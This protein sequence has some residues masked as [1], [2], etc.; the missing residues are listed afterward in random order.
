[1]KFSL[2]VFVV[3]ILGTSSVAE[4]VNMSSYRKDP[5]AFEPYIYSSSGSCGSA[6]LMSFYF[7]IHV[8]R[9][10][11]TVKE[12]RI[13]L[14]S[15][16]GSTPSSTPAIK[17]AIVRAVPEN[18]KP[19]KDSQAIFNPQEPY[20]PIFVSEP[21]SPKTFTLNKEVEVIFDFTQTNEDTPFVFDHHTF[22]YVVMEQCGMTIQITKTEKEFLLINADDSFNTT[23]ALYGAGLNGYFDVSYTLLDF[24]DLQ[25]AGMKEGFTRADYYDN[26]CTCNMGIPDLACQNPEVGPVNA[27]GCS[28]NDLCMLDSCLPNVLGSKEI[29]CP[30][31]NKHFGNDHICECGCIGKSGLPD[32]DCFYPNRYNLRNETTLETDP[33][34]MIGLFHGVVG[35]CGY[36]YPNCTNELWTC[37]PERYND[38]KKCDCFCGYMDADCYDKKIPTDC[39]DDYVC[40]P[41][42][43]ENLTSQECLAPKAWTC[44]PNMYNLT[45]PTYS[46]YTTTCF[47]NCSISSPGCQRS[48]VTKMFCDN[49]RSSSDNDLVCTS[50][51]TCVIAKCGLGYNPNGGRQ[52]DGGLHC[53]AQGS[54]QGSCQCDKTYEPTIPHSKNCVAS[55]GDRFVSDGEECDSSMFCD[56]YTCQCLPGH[57]MVK[58]DKLQY[59]SGCGNL[60][61]DGDE[62]CDGGDGCLSNCLCDELSGYSP[63]D[64]QEDNGCS[65]T[66]NTVPIIVGGA[67]GA[68]VL[69]VSIVVLFIIV[70]H[71][72][73]DEQKAN[74]KVRQSE[75]AIKSAK[76]QNSKI[77]FDSKSALNPQPKSAGPDPSIIA[78]LNVSTQG[79]GME[80]DDDDE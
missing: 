39:H 35:T 26:V 55:C 10:P 5:T 66:T 73:T 63:S 65:H 15:I 13:K 58:T 37:S 75:N 7:N 21:I 51:G 48:S 1:M 70:N 56:N 3:L 36:P 27:K 80:L 40:Y 20:N 45:G 33:G 79:G 12:A 64:N 25:R 50:N 41:T 67:I 74:R 30:Y 6:K 14:V 49:G 34:V 18:F 62:E 4:I 71:Y 78:Q 16:D 46:Q 54:D 38:T 77:T 24:D 59:C 52:C 57:T 23:T 2:L 43:P 11:A 68:V 69:I 53:T 9:F 47:C 8:D 17:A 76:S 22:L 42:D 32:L 29:N 31:H 28:S 44:D 72:K 61:R 60:V 19:S